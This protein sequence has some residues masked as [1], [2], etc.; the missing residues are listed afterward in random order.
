MR[1]PAC[2]VVLARCAGAWC[3]RWRCTARVQRAI[4]TA[5]FRVP[6]MVWH[7]G[8]SS[9]TRRAKPPQDIAALDFVRSVT[10]T[11]YGGCSMARVAVMSLGKRCGPGGNRATRSESSRGRSTA[12]PTMFTVGNMPLGIR[13]ERE[14]EDQS[15]S[16]RDMGTGS[17]DSETLNTLPNVSIGPGPGSMGNGISTSAHVSAQPS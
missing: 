10:S 1:A 5:A 4:R 2:D 9:W 13:G 8:R 7:Q 3:S 12:A 16:L 14:R 11:A 15:E 17:S 6:I